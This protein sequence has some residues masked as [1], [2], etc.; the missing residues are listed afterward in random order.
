MQST[1]DVICIVVLLETA[2]RFKPRIESC[3][4]AFSGISCR[5]DAIVMEMPEGTLRAAKEAAEC[6]DLDGIQTEEIERKTTSNMCHAILECFLRGFQQEVT[7]GIDDSFLSVG[8][9]Q[10]LVPMSGGEL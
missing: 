10:T 4:V 6:L 7:V 2:H 1:Q 8:C 3:N 5:G 9:G